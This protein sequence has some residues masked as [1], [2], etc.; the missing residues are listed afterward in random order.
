MKLKAAGPKTED[1]RAHYRKIQNDILAIK[2]KVEVSEKRVKLDLHEKKQLDVDQQ[3]CVEVQQVVKEQDLMNMVT[4]SRKLKQL[5]ENHRSWM[6]LHKRLKQIQD[7]EIDSLDQEAQRVGQNQRKFQD[8][9]NN[10]K[11]EECEDYVRKIQQQEKLLTEAADAERAR[12]DAFEKKIQEPIVVLKAD[13]SPSQTISHV[14][15]A[16]MVFLRK[17]IARIRASIGSAQSLAKK[18]LTDTMEIKDRSLRT[19]E[20]TVSADDEQALKDFYCA[21]LRKNQQSVPRIKA[22]VDMLEGFLAKSLKNKVADDNKKCQ[23]QI[24][25]TKKQFDSLARKIATLNGKLATAEKGAAALKAS[26][27]NEDFERAAEL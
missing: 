24:S 7:E 1:Q 6:A 14:N 19:S 10:D 11:L 4:Q 9:L 3:E 8:T 15:D 12:L 16:Y 20:A 21:L 18:I 27:E 5:V 13:G 2:S 26:F 17:E 22:D 23:E 25:D